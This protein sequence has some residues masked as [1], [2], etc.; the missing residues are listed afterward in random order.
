MDWA[1]TLTI[2]LTIG[3]LTAAVLHISREDMKLVREDMKRQ[4]EEFS[5]A[6]A[7]WATLLKEI[8]DLQKQI[9][10]IKLDQSKRP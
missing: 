4:D 10:E 7:L 8:S 1:H 2:I 3:A 6:H 9:F 5:K